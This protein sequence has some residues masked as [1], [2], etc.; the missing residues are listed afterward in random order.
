MFLD[1]YIYNGIGNI[2]HPGT[3]IQS[4]T[5]R[6]GEPGA[7]L[8]DLI[9]N[10]SSGHRQHSSGGD[11]PEF[12]NRFISYDQNHA[13]RVPQSAM[14]MPDRQT[15]Q[16]RGG[17]RKHQNQAEQEMNRFCGNSNGGMYMK[18]IFSLVMAGVLSIG[19]LGAPALAESKSAYKPNKNHP[20]VQ[21][22][23]VVALEKDPE[24]VKVKNLESHQKIKEKKNSLKKQGFDLADSIIDYDAFTV[25]SNKARI[26]FVQ[27]AIDEMGYVYRVKFDMKKFD[28]AKAAR[29]LERVLKNSGFKIRYIQP[30]FISEAIGATTQAIN[31]VQTWHYNMVK[32]P[33]AWTVTPGSSSVKVAVLDSGIDHNHQS[34]RNFVNTS[35]GRSF[36][37]TSTTMD[38]HSHGT[39]VAG[40]IVSSGSVSGVMQNA[41]LIPVK[42]LGDDGR[43]SNYGIAQGI[44]YASEIGADV[45]NMSLGGGPY[46][47]TVK[48]ACDTAVSRGTIIAAATGNEEA[49]YIS[50]P[51]AYP[52]CIAVGSV[53]STRA[54][55]WFSNYGTGLE[56]MAPGSDI[57]STTPNNTYSYKS[58]TSMA[59]PHIAGILGLMRSVNPNLSPAQA[60]TILKDTAVPAGPANEY[61]AGIVDAYAAVVAAKGGVVTP[62][63]TSY[64]TVSADKATYQRGESI[65]LTAKVT[66]QN[67]LPL[68]GAAVN[69][70]FTMPSG[71][72][73]TNT[74]ATSSTGIAEWTLT[75]DSTVALGTYSVKADASL[76]GYSSSTASTTLRFVDSSTTQKTVTSI[77]SDKYYYR[78]GETARITITVKDGNGAALPG[79]TVLLTIRRSNG[80]TMNQMTTTNSSG[81]ATLSMTSSSYTATGSYS[82]T[83]SSSLGGYTSSNASTSIYFY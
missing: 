27:D 49:S 66:D 76:I 13:A 51:S 75:S 21:G 47:S 53:D 25:S 5:A 10:I 64:V 16:T 19:L 45:I 62:V 65:R 68:S 18:K 32:V 72:T 50:Y 34:L 63:K 41:T 29:E 60:R 6:A 54:R 81:I 69:F 52:A 56:I 35:L 82:I 22:E 20:S 74:A 39:H 83:A 61:G 37:G 70:T 31:S 71:E 7:I 55:S 12:R 73:L 59:T 38:Y 8:K 36:A 78:R 17:A 58:G 43:G 46:D 40:T 80:T 57:Y 44:L 42:V 2:N 15:G 9:A 33:Q 4:H 24:G 28:E 67:N 14:A 30:N 48:S 79:A 26:D 1:V 77:S 23:L 3:S 11:E